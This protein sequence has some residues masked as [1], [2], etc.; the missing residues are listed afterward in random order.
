MFGFSGKKKFGY[1]VN[2]LIENI[3]R[4]LKKDDL[5]AAVLCGPGNNGSALFIEQLLT[6]KDLWIAAAF[7]DHIRLPSVKTIVSGIPLLPMEKLVGFVN[8]NGIKFAIIA[9]EGKN[10]Q[11]LL[12]ILVLAGIQGVLNLSGAE[13][14][15]AEQ[16]FHHYHLRCPGV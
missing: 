9:T 2:Q 10:A 12:N 15:D 13:I 14:K 4:L 11:R 3:D 7:D 6:A 1:N 8:D 5:T 16:V